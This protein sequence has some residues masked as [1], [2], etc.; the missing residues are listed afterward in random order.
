MFFATP[1]PRGV[2]ALSLALSVFLFVNA[3]IILVSPPL[4]HHEGWVGLATVLWAAVVGGIWTVLTDRVVEWGKAEEEERL[5]GRVE[6]RYT[7]T[8]WLKVILAT[9][10][11]IIVIALEVLITATLFLTMRD[12]SLEPTGRLY[13][14]QGH[15]Y[16]IHVACFGNVS[17]TRPMVFLEGGERSA[18]YFATWVAEAQEEDLIGQ[19]C[20][21][22]RPGY[23]DYLIKTN[24]R[25]A[26]SDNAPSPMSAGAAIDALQAALPKANISTSAK[27]GWILVSHGAGGLY[28]EIFASRHTDQVKGMLFVDAVPES[29]IPKI[30]TAGRTF[31]LLVRGII[32]PLG[33]DRLSASIFKQRT[34]EDRVWGVSSWRSDRVIRSQLQESLAAGAITRNEVIAAEA[35]IPKSV[36]IAVVSSGQRCKDKDW[37]EGQRQLGDKAKRRVWD[38]VGKAGHDVWRNEEGKRLLKKRLSELVNGATL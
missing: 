25:Y 37:E 36:P 4:R 34:R 19:Y 1:L 22:D 31:K 6:D 16:Q 26:F 18:E 30:F 29:L 13:W 5:I 2:R 7:G 11:L 27:P 28:S 9:I 17:T 32:S 38:V 3:V 8:E 21:W 33:I 20:Y 12:A 35:I 15:Q 23:N 14:V 24:A 10:G